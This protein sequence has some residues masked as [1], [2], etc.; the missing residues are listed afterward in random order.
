MR[1]TKRSR[2]FSKCFRNLDR[3]EVSARYERV[4][5]VDGDRGL[6][7]AVERALARPRG[8]RLVSMITVWEI[9]MK[10]GLDLRMAD[11]QTG[12][13]ELGATYCPS[14]SSMLK[15]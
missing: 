4:L 9:I 8:E 10:P 12:V 3:N 11:I 13:A 1:K 7:R 14:N 5:E 15:N 2:I 6:P